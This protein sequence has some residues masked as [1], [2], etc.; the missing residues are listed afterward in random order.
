MVSLDCIPCTVNSFLRL[1][2]TGMLPEESKEAAM[3]RLLAF[4]S[5]ADFRQSP[6]AL[7]REMHRMIREELNNSDPYREIKEKY[8]RMMLDLQPQ[9][10]NQ[11]ETSTDSFDTAMR[12]AVAGNVIDFGPQAQMDIME[13]INRVTRAQFAI[14]D[15]QQ[16]RDDLKSARTLLYLGDNCG[17]IVMDKLFLQTLGLPEMYFAVRGGP[18]INDVTIEDA[19]LVGMEDVATVITT[20]DDSPGVVWETASDE[21]KAIFNEADVIISKG[22]GNLEGLIDVPQNIY[23]L[24]VIKCDLVGELVETGVGE[25]VIKRSPSQEYKSKEITPTEKEV[26]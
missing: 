26:L 7:G 22:Q 19:K 2:K 5:R 16:L 1:I 12:L 23:F 4:L 3:R 14:D 13:T 17:E 25:F 11:I 15:S 18:I 8:N 24:L 20:G 9:F 6:P 10:E 21:F